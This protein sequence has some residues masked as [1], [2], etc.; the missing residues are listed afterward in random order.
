MAKSLQLAQAA[1]ARVHGGTFSSQVA[2]LLNASLCALCP[3]LD[4][5]GRASRG[6]GYPLR[7]MAHDLRSVHPGQVSA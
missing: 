5:E 6:A 1:Y 2:P 3:G 4:P 7:V